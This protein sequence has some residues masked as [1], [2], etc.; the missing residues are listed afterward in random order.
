L[1][2]KNADTNVLQIRRVDVEV[3]DGNS[4]GQVRS[5]V[6]HVS[7]LLKKGQVSNPTEDVF[8]QVQTGKNGNNLFDL[9]SG[10]PVGYYYAD[11]V[12]KKLLS[13][14]YCLP[15]WTEASHIPSRQGLEVRGLALRQLD[16]ESGV[17]M[18][19]GAVWITDFEWYSGANPAQLCIY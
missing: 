18:R 12:E 7:G 8:T 11:S 9:E 10:A 5:G 16:E 17:Y 15:V 2:Q 3:L 13:E 14:V 6:L 1:L 4:F 19:V